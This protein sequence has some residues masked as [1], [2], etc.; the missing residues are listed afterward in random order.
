MNISEKNVME[1]KSLKKNVEN[2]LQKTNG[3][4]IGV[5]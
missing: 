5:Q 4:P 1:L 2:L 3:L